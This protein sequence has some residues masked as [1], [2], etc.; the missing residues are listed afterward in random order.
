MTIAR[1]PYSIMDTPHA[2]ESEPAKNADIVIVNYSHQTY[3]L[4]GA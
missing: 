1:Q 2:L 4:E 3:G